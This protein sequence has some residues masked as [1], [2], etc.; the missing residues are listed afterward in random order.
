MKLKTQ[1]QIKGEVSVENWEE[2]KNREKKYSCKTHD[3]T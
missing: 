3:S 1:F 2:K